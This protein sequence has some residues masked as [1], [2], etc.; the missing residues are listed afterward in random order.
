MD[1]HALLPSTPVVRSRRPATHPSPL[2][3]FFGVVVERRTYAALAYL[4]AGLPLGIAWFTLVVAG[5][6]V[7][8][9]MLSVALLGI[10]V[11][12]GLWYVSRACANVERA[13]ADL[14]LG[15]DLPMAPLL[16][17][18][19]GNPWVRLRT[20][21]GDRERWRELGYLLLRLPTGVLGAVVPIV[22][23]TVSAYLVWAPVEARRADP[24]FGTWRFSPRV[25]ELA[26][27]PWSWLLVPAGALALVLSLHVVNALAAA[28]GRWATDR[29][30]TTG[31]RSVVVAQA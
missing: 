4:L 9:A 10:P 1:D 11:L 3:R 20:M 21:V 27:S 5:V 17:T 2:R 7:G 16:P 26:S 18:Q 19:G 25:E 22:L 24:E 13:L 6:S 28:G 14:L 12:L 15:C 8:V 29:L 31:V 30:R 23:F